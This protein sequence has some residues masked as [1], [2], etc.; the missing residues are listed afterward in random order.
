VIH[1]AGAG[2]DAAAARLG[3]LGRSLTE[4]LAAFDYR[5]QTFNTAARLGDMGAGSALTNVAMAIGRAHH[6]GN[7]V[8]VAGTTDS[9]R[10]VAVVVVPPERPDGAALGAVQFRARSWSSGDLPWWGEAVTQASRGAL[11]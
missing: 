5:K 8:L 11:R 9:E 6:V 2:S 1:D 4:M 3:T 10:P 7:K